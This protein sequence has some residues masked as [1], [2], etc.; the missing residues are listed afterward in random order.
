M[1]LTARRAV[2]A[3]AALVVPAS[4][5]LAGPVATASPGGAHPQP[6]FTVPKGLMFLATGH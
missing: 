6:G 5:V 3:F 2:T 4:L 1:I